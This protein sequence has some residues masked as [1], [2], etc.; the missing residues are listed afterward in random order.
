MTSSILLTGAHVFDPETRSFAERSIGIRD[1]RFCTPDPAGGWNRMMDLA[2][3]IVSPGL[4]DLH[5]HVFD[6]QDLGVAI[7]TLAPQAGV[8]SVVD[9]GSA[10]AHL[11]G[12][13]GRTL[14]DVENVSVVA[15]LNVSSIGT[16]SITLAGELQEAYV[17]ADEAVRAIE[18]RPDLIRGVK[19]RASSNV[20]GPFTDRAL[21]IA[22]EIADRVRLPL[23]VH[24]G[25]APSSVTRILEALGRGDILTHAFTGWPGNTIMQDGVVR[26]EARAARERGVMFD[27]G[28]GASGLSFEVLRQAIDAG[29]A[30]DT[31]S[32]DLH[33]YSVTQVVDLPSVMSKCLASGMSLARVLEATT[34]VPA[35]VAGTDAGALRDGAVA[36]V[37]VLRRASRAEDYLDAFGGALRTTEQLDVVT[38]IRAGR[39]VYE[40]D[41]A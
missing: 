6:G 39:V 14:R 5:T 13:F 23:M 24:L 30:P 4:V 33:A 38:T 20:G 7:D 32:S 31:I 40:R 28:H 16:T 29:F 15:F 3:A 8:T 17:D 25:P 37:V 19:V 34:L 26:A 18:S 22:R 36:D 12:A 41:G 9:A 2:G 1:G 27:V 21:Q 10:G 35:R 11:L